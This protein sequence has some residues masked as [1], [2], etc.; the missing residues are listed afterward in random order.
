MSIEIEVEAQ[1]DHLD[2]LA[3]AKPVNALAELLWNS[4]DADAS[5]VEVDVE[6]NGLGGVEEI[7]VRD[8]GLGIPFDE[9]NECF[10]K[11]GG[12]WKKG[13]SRTQGQKRVLHGKEGKGRFKA[14]ALGRRVTWETVFG[15]NGEKAAYSISGDRI[16]LKK[17][18]ITDP[19]PSPGAP[20][21]TIV[22]IRETPD[23][24]GDLSLD[25][26]APDKL[27]E[28]FA[29]YLRDYPAVSLFFRGAKIRPDAAQ[30]D[31]REYD[32]KEIDLGGGRKTTAVLQIVEWETRKGRKLCL[33]DEG[34]FTYREIEAGIR[35]GSEFQFTAYIRSPLIEELKAEN[36]LELEDLDPALS[37]LID[38]SRNRM[39]AHFRAKKAHAAADLVQDWKDEGIYP[40]QGEAADPIEAARRQVFEICAFNVHEYLDDFQKADTKSRKF[41]FRMLREALEDNPAALQKIFQDVL[42][43]PK[44]KQEEL[45]ELLDRTTLSAII[46][47]NKLITDRL[48]FLKGLEE[49][50]FNKDSK[51]ELEE[52]SQLH[53]ILEEET[54]IF[55]EEFH[56]TSSDQ[57]LTTVL[58]KQLKKLRP[59]ENVEK[60]IRDDGRQAVID[61]MLAREIPQN[62]KNR[63]EFL[64]VELKR[65]SQKIDLDVKGQIESYAY[66]V[67]EDERFDINNTYWTFIAVSNEMSGPALKSVNQPALPRGYFN[68]SDNYRIGL[69][70]WAEIL[71]NCRT[72]LELFQEKLGY[73]ATVDD[74]LAV[75]RE[76][77]AKYL[78]EALNGCNDDMSDM[79]E[80]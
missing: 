45:A 66:A 23:D 57:T 46:E 50:L 53:K 32:L 64:V 7:V 43:L 37:T 8:N 13:A 25:G 70:T 38:I 68:V 1:P 74:G 28:F 9:A 19:S 61:L 72:R 16:N 30:R 22:R 76:R 34:G 17:F 14:F 41:T 67:V 29:L 78:P 4:F 65:P 40:Y 79:D 44:E 12:S 42:D 55:G 63:R 3:N 10:R 27:T 54:W 26:K 6:E 73:T 62:R 20:T 36:R 52:R 39:R 71:L 21:G 48:A 59:G 56:L 5:V 58:G 75:L 31:F 69:I 77:Y 33:C 24:L 2:S 47:A 49:L 80:V 35:P 15:T 18:S 51:R 11:L 60:V